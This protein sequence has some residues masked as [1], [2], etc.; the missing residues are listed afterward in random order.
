MARILRKKNYVFE[1]TANFFRCS[2]KTWSETS[3]VSTG[4]PPSYNEIQ[5][6]YRIKKYSHQVIKS[7]NM[8]HP[9]PGNYVITSFVVFCFQDIPISYEYQMNRILYSVG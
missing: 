3:S 4:A 5:N 1:E 7:A 6:Q 2:M 9:T 8:K